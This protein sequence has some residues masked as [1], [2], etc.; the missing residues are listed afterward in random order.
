MKNITIFFRTVYL[1]IEAL[2]S[3]Q[4]KLNE[5]QP[6]AIMKGIC[7][8]QGTQRGPLLLARIS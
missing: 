8:N 1:V 3:S 7:D 2:F 4:T 5:T 6:R